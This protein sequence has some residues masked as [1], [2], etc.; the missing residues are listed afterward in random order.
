MRAFLFSLFVLIS[1][2][3]FG[4]TN[5]QSFDKM[6]KSYY[7]KT[8]PL[9]YPHQL[10]KKLLNG[11]KVYVLD[12]REKVEYN[13]SFIQGAI[14]VGY[15]NFSITSVKELNKN[16]NVIVYCTIGAR[17]ETVGE[18]L[19]KNGFTNVYNL[20][21]G[22]IYWQNKGYPLYNAPKTKTNSVHVYSK[23]WGKW[24]TKGKAIY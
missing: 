10:Y 19:K 24:L 1:I 6:V 4:Q 8:V 13:V 11:E 3:S 17:S 15:D 5:E 2:G 21:G 20:Y 9:I 18:K 12:T 22:L 7:K 14:H 23:E 16:T